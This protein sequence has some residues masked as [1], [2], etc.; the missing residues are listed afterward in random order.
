MKF[1]SQ[2]IRKIKMKPL[3]VLLVIVIL[4]LF[5]CQKDEVLP[6]TGFEEVTL[7]SL[8]LDGCT[9]VFTK[10]DTKYLEPNNL[11][12]YLTTFT[13]GKKYWIRYKLDKNNA[14]ICMVGNQIQIVELSDH[15]K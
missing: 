4:S 14:S 2:T 7:K 3:K 1:I 6:A 5:C 15:A 8:V 11:D 10:T 9:W 12:D 13:D